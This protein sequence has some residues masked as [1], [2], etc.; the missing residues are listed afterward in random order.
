MGPR[1]P[2]ARER[3]FQGL[4]TPTFLPLLDSGGSTTPHSMSPDSPPPVLLSPPPAPAAPRPPTVA[5]SVAPAAEEASPRSPSSRPP[6]ASSTPLAR[7]TAERQPT[8]G[9]VSSVD[10][11]GSEGG[12]VRR[13][14]LRRSS[15]STKGSPRHVRFD[16]HG[17]EVLP[18][19]SPPEFA[20]GAGSPPDPP[21]PLSGA[22]PPPLG[23]G[24]SAMDDSPAYTGPSLMDMEGEED[25]LPKPRKVSSTQALRALSRSPLDEGTVW[26][27]VNPSAEETPGNMASTPSSSQSA[28]V[29]AMQPVSNHVEF[30]SSSEEKGRTSKDSE[31]KSKTRGVERED[32]EN[33]DE[34]DS[35]EDEEFLSMRPKATT[36]SPS[37]SSVRS[38]LARSPARGSPLLFN[39]N[40]NATLSP[41]KTAQAFE[42]SLA[43]GT[44]RDSSSAFAGAMHDEDEVE[45]EE[46][47]D[48]DEDQ[49][50]AAAVA[51][52]GKS[53][54]KHGKY[55][56]ES[57]DDSSE[58][59]DNPSL[60]PVRHSLAPFPGSPSR[61]V[62]RRAAAADRELSSSATGAG[63]LLQG[64]VGS[65]KG[66]PL[67]MG[68]VVNPEVEA[69]AA[70]MGEFSTFVGSVHDRAVDS[71]E[72]AS[73]R[74]SYARGIP[75][76]FSQRVAL[77]TAAGEDEDDM[78][79]LS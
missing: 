62:P 53:V 25:L 57:S 27:V 58:P 42:D 56:S 8:D 77:E 18:S 4:F 61:P 55:L 52:S 70:S 28:A 49:G 78:G 76:S 54:R 68:V 79:A 63:K 32:D 37:P 3:E 45:D 6:H 7:P 65:Y 71:S 5:D 22:E 12:K 16:L 24:A 59:A 48:F 74:A 66:Q 50:E 33:V 2:H 21:P 1:S 19:T 40:A 43:T 29:T 13:S 39:A 72:L 14:A 69:Q 9:T 26:T 20:V 23:S 34:E 51:R 15:S 31:K 38:P 36:K 35:S 30:S 46:L 17:V 64:S 67:R 47:F 41:R 60:P 75:L 44:I 11:S 10:S 73:Y